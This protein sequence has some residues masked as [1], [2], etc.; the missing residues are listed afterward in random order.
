MAELVHTDSGNGFHPYH[1]IFH[2]MVARERE[3]I[4]S[5]KKDALLIDH[6]VEWI[7]EQ[8]EADPQRAAVRRGHPSPDRVASQVALG[9]F[10]L[11]SATKR[12]D[13]EPEKLLT[14]NK[15]L[16]WDLARARMR[17]GNGAAAAAEPE[18][19]PDY[20]FAVV[21]AETFGRLLGRVTQS[22]DVAPLARY[23]SHLA[24][25][26]N[27]AERAPHVSRVVRST[28]DRTSRGLGLEAAA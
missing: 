16:G 26:Q 5:S 18:L 20:R 2:G 12:V 21:Q 8:L 22:L 7:D 1:D 11:H 9:F 4:A 14:D 24:R 15:A 17:D 27:E 28:L 25:W 6:L 13:F 10:L 19:D 3:K 23:A